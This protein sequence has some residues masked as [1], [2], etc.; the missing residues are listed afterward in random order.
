MESRSFWIKVLRHLAQ[1][2]RV[3]KTLVLISGLVCVLASMLLSDDFQAGMAAIGAAILASVFSSF[4]LQIFPADSL[5]STVRSAGLRDVYQ[6][7][8]I[9]DEDEW[10]RLLMDADDNVDLAGRS[11]YK[12][13]DSES[14]RKKFSEIVFQKT[15][16][17]KFRILL[18]STDNTFLAALEEEEESLRRSL[19]PKLERVE[20]FLLE[21]A[22]QLTDRQKKNFEVKCN[23]T[24]AFYRSISRFDSCLYIIPYFE[25]KETN[26]CPLIEIDGKK[27][28]LFRL[29]L[30]AF[31]ASWNDER[32]RRLLGGQEDLAGPSKLEDLLGRHQI[33][34]HFSIMTKLKRESSYF[35]GDFNEG[36]R[37]LFKY[38]R[39]SSPEK[40]VLYDYTMAGVARASFK[41]YNFVGYPPLAVQS[42]RDFGFSIRLM[43]ARDTRDLECLKQGE[44]YLYDFL[45]NG[46]SRN[47]SF[48]KMLEI[49]RDD[50][51][52]FLQFTVVPGEKIAGLLRKPFNVYG[53]LVASRSHIFDPVVT[54]RLEVLWDPGAVR[55]HLEVFVDLWDEFKSVQDV[56]RAPAG[57]TGENLA[58]FDFEAYKNA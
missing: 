34:E 36:W 14:K 42:A 21:L 43:L 16:D 4:L 53:G 9:F 20:R 56:F 5:D 8:K 35:F 10:F 40:K 46:Y 7:A 12:W 55:E 15:L 30:S 28:P 22:R 52:K 1:R 37:F 57:V 49:S 51:K 32:N 48:D 27:S 50:E 6:P 38:M 41:G 25:Y 19:V 45:R 39:D 11:L 29:Y 33:S 23:S 54:P 18:M 47:A 24:Q 58:N 26:E 13:I 44:Q 31:E 2:S 3:Y 17:T